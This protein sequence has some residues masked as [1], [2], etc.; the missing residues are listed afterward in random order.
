[1][2]RPTPRLNF[3]KS[4]CRDWDRDW[5]YIVS[6]SRLRPRL[7]VSESQ[8]RDRD[9]DWICKVSMSRL[10]PRLNS[11]KS[12]Y[13][14]WDRDWIYNLYLPIFTYIYNLYLPIFTYIYNLYFEIQFMLRPRLIETI[15]FC[16]CRDRDSSRLGISVV[17]ETETHRDWEILWLS[18][19][20]LIET[21]KFCGVETET[22]RDWEILWLSRPRLI[23]TGN[24][25]GC[26]DRDQPRLNKSCRDR[27]FIESLADLCH[28][29]VNKCLFDVCKTSLGSNKLRP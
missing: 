6:M 16:G 18:R 10:R 23:E 1:M 17:V 4:Q 9:R 26:R 2:S 12:Q 29:K 25:C 5:I 28:S 27:D 20:R 13:R 21:G 24:F 19:P 14:D 7:K 22:H 15:K 11:Q 3:F 8:C